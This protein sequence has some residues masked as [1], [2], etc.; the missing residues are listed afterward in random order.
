MGTVEKF[1]EQ[2][3][4]GDKCEEVS[5][6]RVIVPKALDGVEAFGMRSAERRKLNVLEMKCFIRL[7]EVSRTDILRNEVRRR[8]VIQRELANRED[9]RILRWFQMVW[10][11]RMDEGCG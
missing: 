4:F 1:T 10:D 2:E 9:Q 5:I 6:R 11:Q 8:A 7:V 3:G